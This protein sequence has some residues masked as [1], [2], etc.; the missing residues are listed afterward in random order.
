MKIVII[1]ERY[2]VVHSRQEMGDVALKIL[3]E[4]RNIGMLEPTLHKVVERVCDE[5]DGQFAIEILPHV[6]YEVRI[7]TPE[8]VR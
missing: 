5:I 3:N 6:A 8:P 4:R 7:V 2:F 1:E